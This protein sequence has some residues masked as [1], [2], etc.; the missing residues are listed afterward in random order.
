MARVVA[1]QAMSTE[2]IVVTSLVI[3][4]EAALDTAV[5]D[6]ELVQQAAAW[7]ADRLVEG[8]EEVGFAIRGKELRHTRQG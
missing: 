6:I 4:A 2:S 8:K 1:Q 7:E 5:G 3:G